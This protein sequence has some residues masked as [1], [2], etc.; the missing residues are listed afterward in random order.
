[1]GPF[2]GHHMAG[3]PRQRPRLAKT[4]WCTRPSHHPPMDAPCL[5]CCL[6]GHPALSTLPPLV[7]PP[8]QQAAAPC[9]TL[10]G[11]TSVLGGGWRQAG[12]F[13]L[14]RH[15]AHI[16]R[17]VQLA[18]LL[19]CRLLGLNRADGFDVALLRHIPAGRERNAGWRVSRPGQD[20]DRAADQ[21]FA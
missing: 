15:D 9:P 13:A 10:G 6:P 3:S 2:S 20:S 16:A 11:C 18:Q 12:R 21:G 5:P 4:L 7:A 17:P 19:H 8:P 1:M 14:P